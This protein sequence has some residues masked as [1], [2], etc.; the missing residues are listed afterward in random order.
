MFKLYDS[1]KILFLHSCD[2]SK[3]YGGKPLPLIG[4]N[5][6]KH[7]NLTVEEEEA[8]YTKGW[9]VTDKLNTITLIL[10]EKSLD[11]KL[12]KLVKSQ[13]FLYEDLLHKLEDSA[14]RNSKGQYTCISC[15]QDLFNY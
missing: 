5:Y 15:V 3:C 10:L 2:G 14:Y 7:L 6:L 11:V 9:Y 12:R 1:S 8:L 13:G 4:S